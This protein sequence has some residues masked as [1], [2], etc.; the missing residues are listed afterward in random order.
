MAARTIV[1]KVKFLVDYAKDGFKF[2]VGQQ[3]LLFSKNGDNWKV[4]PLE[5]STST[6]SEGGYTAA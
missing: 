2:S 6:L 1:G 5:Y 3:A 4:R